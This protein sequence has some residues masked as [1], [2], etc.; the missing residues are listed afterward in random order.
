MKTAHRIPL[1][2]ALCTAGL[3]AVAGLAA[4]QCMPDVPTGTGPNC[5]TPVEDPVEISTPALGPGLP[6]LVRLPFTAAGSQ[7]VFLTGLRLPT[8]GGAVAAREPGRADVR[9]WGEWNTP[10]GVR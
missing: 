10:A 9:R 6:F 5:V 3:L 4:A 8:W 2:L 7:W 1:A